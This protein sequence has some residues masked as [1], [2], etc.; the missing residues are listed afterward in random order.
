MR[1]ASQ[2]L[3]LRFAEAIEQGVIFV[4][5]LLVVVIA[6]IVAIQQHTKPRHCVVKLGKSFLRGGHRGPPVTAV[7]S[8]R[9]AVERA[10][11]R[12]YTRTY[13]KIV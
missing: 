3:V 11:G 6:E 9:A 10:S 5:G 4:V 7:A 8:P 2:Y 1:S 13:L 12:D